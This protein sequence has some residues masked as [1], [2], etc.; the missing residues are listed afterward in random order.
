MRGLRRHFRDLTFH[1][2]LD[3]AFDDL[4]VPYRAVVTDYA[5]GDAVAL[6]R[7]DLVQAMLASMAVPGAFPPREIDGRL[8]V[9]GGMAAQLPVRLARDMGA[10]IIIAIDTT[11]EPPVPTAA[12]SMAATLQQLIRVTVWRNRQADVAALGEAD[13]L[14]TPDLNGLSTTAFDRAPHGVSAGIDAARAQADRL[15]QISIQAAPSRRRSLALTRPA[16][17]AAAPMRIVNHTSLD[18]ALLSARA[19]VGDTLERE[20]SLLSQR[21]NALTAFGALGEVDLAQDETGLVLM[22]E[23]RDIGRSQI[24]G[25]LRLSNTFAGD[26]TF[27]VLA[28]Y[29]RRPFSRHGGDF[30][31]SMEL[32]TTNGLEAVLQQPFGAAGRYFYEPSVYYEGEEVPLNIGD[33]RLGEFWDQ[34]AGARLRVGRELGDWGVIYAGGEVRRGRTETKVSLLAGLEP[35]VY[36]LAG[37]G[38]GVRLDTLDRVSWPTRGMAL[39]AEAFQLFSVGDQGSNTIQLEA[40]ARRT[41]AVGDVHLLGTLNAGRV[42]N[43][44]DDPV[45]LI[46]LGGFRRLSA[47]AQNAIP[48]NGYVYGSV[49]AYQRLDQAGA[50]FDVPVYVGLLVEAA[51]LELDLLTPGAAGESYS[52]AVYL[53]VDTVL[54][55]VILGGALGEEGAGGVFFHLGSSF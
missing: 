33:L 2:P 38:G 35:I 37:F 44:N 27:S 45:D 52:G 47:Y 8:Y 9:D 29:S 42:Q 13:L 10:D 21:L 40:L 11:V 1:V 43:E 23:E 36:T 49:E 26:S 30:S 12:P 3:A 54:G 24:E 7:G 17:L 48:T 25:G 32:G 51:R 15:R 4:A 5:T 6:A 46:T 28:R 41:F 34:K 20:D 53:G 55:P 22:V 31:L 19:D 39:S 50:M 14:L 18:D 16:D